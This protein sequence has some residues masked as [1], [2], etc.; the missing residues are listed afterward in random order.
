M[1][2]RKDPFD[3]V[4]GMSEAN[5]AHVLV[6]VLT[7]GSD[8]TEGTP[9]N[10][11]NGGPTAMER[12]FGRRVTAVI[13]AALLSR[14]YQREVVLAEV[15]DLLDIGHV[16]T[17]RERNRLVRNAMIVFAERAKRGEP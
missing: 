6:S 9:G 10:I 13:V 4:A 14:R 16:R 5:F 15:M 3:A 1:S 17:L 2:T 7:A 11:A 12:A 8:V